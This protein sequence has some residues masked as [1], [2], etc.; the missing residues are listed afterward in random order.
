MSSLQDIFVVDISTT[1]AG[2]WATRTLA[3]LGAQVV[4]VEDQ[5]GH[6]LRRLAPFDAEGVSVPA[7]YFLAGKRSVHLDVHDEAERAALRRL[8]GRCDILVSSYSPSELQRLG[9]RYDDL[10]RP[11][12]VML[13]VTPYGMTGP[14]AEQAG[15]DLTVAALSGWASINGRA[16]REPLR[17]HGFHV[18][19]CTGVVAAG[20]A[21]AALIPRDAGGSG[22]EV[23]VAALDVMTS[24]FASILLKS[25]YE[26]VAQPRQADSDVTTG[27]VPV[28]DGHFALT[29]SRAH[30]WRDAMYLLDLP[31]LAE[32]PRWELGYFRKANKDEYTRRVQE[33][34]LNWTKMELFD[35]LAIRRVVAGPVLTMSELLANDHLRERGFW[36]RVEGDERDYP[37]AIFRMSETPLTPG[38]QAPQR[39]QH[40][41]E[42]LHRLREGAS[43]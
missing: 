2:A 29:L 37:G 26:G 11:S 17:P 32:D 24:F 40:T 3:S 27:P 4:M 42:F 36:G 7:S 5:A 38:N 10:D 15:D 16:D 18:A 30:F 21:V 20:A 19:Y 34:M 25:Q 28:A 33:Q 9:L 12:L 14:L 43:S 8:V 23:D 22:Q 13:H 1:P 35:E 6:P 31:D 39:A 41:D